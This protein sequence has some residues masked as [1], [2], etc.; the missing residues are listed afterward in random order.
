M[1]KDCSYFASFITGFIDDELNSSDKKKV[2]IHLDKC[3]DCNEL[4]VDEVNVKRIIKERI[5]IVKAPAYLQRR[6]RRQLIRNGNRPGFW[7]LIQSIFVYQPFPASFALAIM[8]CLVFLPLFQM[9]GNPAN[10]TMTN[11]S[12]SDFVKKEAVL[13]GDIICL[14]C[15]YLSQNLD[16]AKH[17]SE[18][19]RSGI[20]TDD[21]NI[22]TIVNS[23][24]YETIAHNK[25]I[26]GKKAEVRGL[27]FKNSHYIYVND[28][29]LL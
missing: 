20:R 1:E 14:D 2:E 27:L 24:D 25:N 22:W 5:P 29:K 26:S 13:K 21:E 16:I 3:P 10:M 18:L 19:H 28:L 11:Q 6:I 23:E 8:I 4:Y 9:M 7:Q 12:D 15:E 17:P